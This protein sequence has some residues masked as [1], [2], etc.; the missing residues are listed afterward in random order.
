MSQKLSTS[1]R[2]RKSAKRLFL[3]EKSLKSKNPSLVSVGSIIA[4][5]SQ[6]ASEYAKQLIE[7]QKVRRLYGI[8]ENQFKKYYIYASKS[9]ENTAE[10]MLQLLERRLDNAVYRAGL[11]STRA[12]SRQLVSH[13]LIKLNGKR[14]NIPSI[15]VNVGDKFE[16]VKVTERMESI[17]VEMLPKWLDKD[18]KT[19]AVKIASLPTREDV[20]QD[21]NEQL[22]VE[23][24]SK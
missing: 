17:E 2:Y 4:S 8:N 3:R 1:P 7:K 12:E 21:I 20:D 10:I 13:K 18:K 22:I 15:K 14:V 16:P 23:Y 6:R 11:A 5:Q 24:Y 19:L 9:G